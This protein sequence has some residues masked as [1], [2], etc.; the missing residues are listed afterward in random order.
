ME[1]PGAVCTIGRGAASGRLGQPASLQ[2]G[3]NGQAG[4]VVKVFHVQCAIC[5]EERWGAIDKVANDVIVGDVRTV[6]ASVV[7]EG[8]DLLSNV[9]KCSKNLWGN[10]ALGR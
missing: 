7:D 9:R 4:P 10:R 1:G 5:L 6:L 8:V 3:C 2:K